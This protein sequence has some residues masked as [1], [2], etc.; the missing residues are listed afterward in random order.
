MAFHKGGREPL[1]PP[2]EAAAARY[3]PDDQAVVDAVRVHAFAGTAE[4]VAQQLHDEARRLALDELV[5][6][7]WT[8]DLA[9]RLRSTTLLAQ[10]FG[11]Q[12]ATVTPAS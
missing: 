9:A 6:V 1:I 11:L 7:T 5:V 12:P 8:Y 4:R 2:E 10:A 3:A